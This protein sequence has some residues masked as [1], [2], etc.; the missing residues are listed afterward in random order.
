MG[1]V[2]A[3]AGAQRV[4]LTDRADDGGRVLA[5]LRAAVRLNGLVADVAALTWGDLTAA[6]EL[7][8]VPDVIL[9]ADCFYA[10]RDFES[11]IATVAV[12]LRRHADLH[13]PATPRACFV[14]SYHERSAR[15]TIQHQLDAWCLVARLEPWR[16]RPGQGAL[17]DQLPARD[18][19]S[20]WLLVIELAA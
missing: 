14:T 6:R 16:P 7:A 4:V 19:A 13:G 11:V 20:L 17:S 8:C 10:V 12:L 2:A 15:R 1:V 3:R 9:G 18:L 5:G